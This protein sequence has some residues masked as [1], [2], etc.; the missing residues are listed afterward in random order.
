MSGRIYL[1]EITREDLKTSVKWTNDLDFMVLQTT[2]PLRPQSMEDEIRWFENLPKYAGKVFNYN[3]RT[4]E[5]DTL[6]GFV[7]YSSRGQYPAACG[8]DTAAID[9]QHHLC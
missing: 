7:V 4:T 5:D 2:G 6:I 1:G 8:G 3:I 9:A